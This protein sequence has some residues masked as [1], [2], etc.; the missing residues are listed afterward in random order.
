MLNTARPIVLRTS[1]GMSRLRLMLLMLAGAAA[2]LL[3]AACGEV[4]DV[5]EISEDGSGVQTLAVTISESDMEDIDGGAKAVESV[6]EAKNPGL[7]YEGMTKDGTDTVFTLTLEFADAKD[8]AKKAQPVLAAG[9]LSKTA[10]V[11][12]TPPSPPF[13]SGYTLTRNFTAKE[14]T[15]WAVKALFDDGKLGSDSESDIDQAL[16][17]GDVTVEVEGTSLERTSTFGDDSAP[18]WTSAQSVGFDSVNVVTTGAEDPSADS[19]TR[20]LTYELKRETYL[21]AKDEF[22]AFFSEATPEGGDLTPAEE[23]G[24]TW[25]LAFPAGTAE[26]VGTWTD[27]ALATSESTF[28]VETSPNSEDPF[29]IDT[30]V[31]DSIECA[32]ACGESGTLS[33]ALQV[34]AGFTGGEVEDPE[35]T[36]EIALD[37]GPEPQV[38]TKNITFSE[39]S[40]AVTVNRDGG[41]SAT[42]KLSLPAADDEVVTADNVTDFLGEGTERSESGDLVTYTRTAEADTSSDFSGALQ[43]LGFE[44]VEGAPEVSVSERSDGDYSV[45]LAM[46]VNEKLMSKIS[47]EGSWTIDGDGLRPIAVV[48]DQTGSAALGEEAVTVDGS[49]GVIL[50]VTAERTGLGVGAIVGIVV[51]LAVVGLA[52]AA[53]VLGYLYRGRIK[54]LLGGS[55]PEGPGAV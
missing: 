12:F 8:Y 27:A 28:S 32:V 41:G 46:G 19:Y 48:E 7:S 18:E 11:T 49:H 17:A 51:L 35:G 9:D 5:T 45:S 15:R 52:I 21:D 30:R 2:M 24:T 16:D 26:Q 37:G 42:M 39:A 38:I 20:T 31:V 6:I 13:S 3:L 44:G 34:P 55:S 10:E 22:D 36:E 1:W 29:A 25:V 53:G 47:A 54:S 43:K 33:Q 50:N 4:D 23:T 40:Y 14:L